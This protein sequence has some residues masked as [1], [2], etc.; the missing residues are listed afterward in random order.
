MRIPTMRHVV[1]WLAVL[2]ACSNAG[3]DI[4]FGPLPTG[5]VNVLVFLDRDG[6]AT[7]TALDTVFTS[8]RVALLAPQSDDTIRVKLSDAQ[9]VAVFDTVP[10]GQY[11]VVIDT[12]SIGDSLIVAAIDSA[13]V[14]LNAGDPPFGVVAR[15]AFP[16]VS[17][18]AARTLA[19]GKRVF[20]RGIILA[21]VQ[22]FSDTTAHLADTSGTLRLTEVSLAAGLTGNSP[23]DSVVVLGRVGVRSG[24]PVLTMSR[25]IRIASR[26][27]PIP[28]AVS[29]ANAASANG[30]AL[31]A[32]LIQ[33]TS[34]LISDTAT[35]APNFRVTVSDGTGN[36]TVLLDANILFLRT[37]FAPGRSMNTRGVL[38]PDGL[39]QWMLKPRVG[40]DVILN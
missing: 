27:A 36:L 10:I 23:G 16:E 29:T 15:L 39:G 14:R 35:V 17:L 31:D 11:R 22:S 8:A 30:G 20:V 12:R 13:S 5:Q 34:A 6:S 25:L 38:V 19:L 24:Q 28:F 21:G 1:A 26:P 3:D 32:A 33:I 40:N 7:A 2:S 9:G 18:R 4:T 37:A